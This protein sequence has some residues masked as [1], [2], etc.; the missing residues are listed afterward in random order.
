MVDPGA[1]TAAAKRWTQG[2]A[3]FRLFAI[4]LLPV[5]Q[6]MMRRNNDVALFG[7]EHSVVSIADGGAHSRASTQRGCTSSGPPAVRWPRQERMASAHEVEHA[8]AENR[9]YEGLSSLRDR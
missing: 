6:G 5:A 1:A 9:C 2:Y 8:E 3:L 7:T 4:V